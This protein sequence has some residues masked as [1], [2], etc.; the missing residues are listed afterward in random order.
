[1]TAPAALAATGLVVSRGAFA[2]RADLAVPAG[3]TALLG[4]SGSG[5]ST[6]LLALAGLVRPSAG[7]VTLGGE[8]LFDA[9][10]RHFVPAWRRG[11]GLVFQTPR[12]WPHRR[13]LATIRY[14][15]RY[16]ED[17]VIAWCGLAPLLDRYPHA[18]SGGEAQRVAIARALM[19]R[20]RALL[21][22]EPFTGLDPERRRGLREVFQRVQR[23][24]ALPVL[25][26]THLIPEAL[27]LT[28]RLVLLEA[29]AVRAQGDL[30]AVL[31]EPAAAALA[32]SLGLENLL[33]V[34]VEGHADGT[35]HAR[36]GPA[37]LTLPALDAPP[38]ARVRVAVRPEDVLV[39]TAPLH[40][41][42]ARNVLSGPLLAVTPLADRLLV[43]IDVGQPLRAEVT[44]D[45]ARE[46]GLETGQSVFAYVKTWAWR[47]RP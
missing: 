35:T 8:L 5:K 16:R 10:A 7:R 1:M 36:L 44:R 26:A 21:L 41:V 24:L 22:D 40:G 42:S 37:R 46:L 43:L 12:L 33:E 32:T 9:A 25:F 13:V 38:G 6:L 23:E 29:G 15:G 28:E 30:A 34:E 45:A 31:A 4:P 11:V 19:A 14:G 17:D 27:E 3:I 47:P 39:A 18:L 20:P 2:L